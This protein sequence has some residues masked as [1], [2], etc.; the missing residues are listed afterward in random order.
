MDNAKPRR[1]D[2]L[3]VRTGWGDHGAHTRP[4]P[5]YIL[6]SSH[7]SLEGAELLASRMSS[8]GQDLLL[9]DTALIGWPDKHLIPEWCSLEPR[10]GP[11]PSP[12]AKVYLHLYT[13]EKMKED[14][15]VELGLLG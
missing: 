12:E 2:A 1:G 9:A 13:E 15:A 11:W 7:F 5:G 8:A 4:G 6:E 3:L 10:P 14:F